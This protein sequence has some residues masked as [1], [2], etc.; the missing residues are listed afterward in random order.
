MSGDVNLAKNLWLERSWTL[1]EILKLPF[2][3]MIMGSPSVVDRNP[4]IYLQMNAGF[5]PYQRHFFLRQLEAT[6]KNHNQTKRKC[7]GLIDYK[8][9]GPNLDICK[10]THMLKT[11]GA[12]KQ[13]KQKDHKSQDFRMTATIYVASFRHDRDF[14][15]MN[16]PRLGNL[17]KTVWVN[18][19]MRMGK[20]WPRL[21]SQRHCTQSTVAKG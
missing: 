10:T 6:I 7:K 14:A 15:F 4:Y 18:M 13:R 9:P 17:Y 19:P 5:T 20:T 1:E 11:Q 8:V 12:S 16:S 3:L 2:S 21:Q